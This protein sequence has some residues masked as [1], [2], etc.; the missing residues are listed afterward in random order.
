MSCHHRL[1]SLVFVFVSL[2]GCTT[3]PDLPKD[4]DP[5][6]AMSL[7]GEHANHF[8]GKDPR[9]ILVI[10]D[11]HSASPGFRRVRL[12]LRRIQRE[13]RLL[14]ENFLGHGYRVLGCE[15]PFG[16]L[17]ETEDTAREYRIV[18][19]WMFPKDTLDEYGVF[20]PLRFQLMYPEL[21][22]W[23]VE[24]PTLHEKDRK[25]WET[26]VA[27]TARA[28]RKDQSETDRAAHLAG[29]ARA[30]RDLNRN[31]SARGRAAAL[32]LLEVLD[33]LGRKRGILILGG[34]HIPAALE[35]FRQRDI[36]YDVYRSHHYDE[37]PDVED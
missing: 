7:L 32:N 8:E 19:T 20:Q 2:L 30:A 15:Y 10:M 37:H 11:R 6:R 36:S 31:V 34:A 29:A 4:V 13:H 9:R 28:R 26:Y 14:V 3:A 24:D 18:R 17:E 25:S 23:G 5:V 27:E 1:L 21:R 22:V 12:Q 33:R 35:V 16:P